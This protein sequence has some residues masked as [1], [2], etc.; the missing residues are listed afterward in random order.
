MSIQKRPQRFHAGEVLQA[1]VR[2][3]GLT[4]AGTEA[5]R[6]GRKRRFL[7]ILLRRFWTTLFQR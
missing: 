5:I 4:L 2:D 1:D 3:F 6:H 7:D